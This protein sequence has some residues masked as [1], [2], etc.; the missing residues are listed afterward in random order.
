MLQSHLG[1]GWRERR[2]E[3][4]ARFATRKEQDPDLPPSSS[5]WKPSLKQVHTQ[6]R[7]MKV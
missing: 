5:T 2:V 4:G 7:V 1:K 3:N 6:K